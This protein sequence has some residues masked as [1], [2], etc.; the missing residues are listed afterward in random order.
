MVFPASA[1]ALPLRSA[2]PNLLAILERSLGS[3]HD[4]ARVERE[5]PSMSARI[6]ASLL[7]A[8]RTNRYDIVSIARSL[9]VTPRKLQRALKEEST[10][11]NAIRDEL[12]YT[13]ASRYLDEGLSIAEISF[14]L[15]FSEPS[16][17]F[18]AFKRWSGT[19]PIESRALRHAPS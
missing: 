17:F 14:L 15:G 13:L 3:K 12:R 8:L 1:F 4:G 9:A 2:D 18:R 19:T 16:A 10:S 7:E 11:F 6:R 5:P